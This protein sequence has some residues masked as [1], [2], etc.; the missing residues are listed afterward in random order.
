MTKFLTYSF[1]LVVVCGACL[2]ALAPSI[3]SPITTIPTTIFS[4]TSVESPES[5]TTIPTSVGK[6][7]S[8][9]GEYTPSNGDDIDCDQAEDLYDSGQL[10]DVADFCD[11]GPDGEWDTEDN[12]DGW[13]E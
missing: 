5:S 10:D 4:P 11:Y 8:P 2:E 1:F 6:S 7:G 9:S 3:D 13:E 12:Y